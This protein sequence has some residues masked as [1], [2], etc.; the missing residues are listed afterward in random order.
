[1]EKKLTR[2]E[3]TQCQVRSRFIMVTACA[4]AAEEEEG[5][6]EGGRPGGQVGGLGRGA[7]RGPA[8]T[9]RHVVGPYKE[10]DNRK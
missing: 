5:G 6:G 9:E 3:P 10:R 8:T 4:W 2:Y 7:V 1:M